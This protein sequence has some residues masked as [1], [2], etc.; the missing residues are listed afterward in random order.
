MSEQKMKQQRLMTVTMESLV[1][2][3]HFL[4]K[5][6]A[7]VDMDFIYEL[8]R[9][10]YSRRGRPSIDPVTLIKSLLIGYLYGIDSE[11]K[12]EKEIQVNIA[13]RRYIRLDLEDSVPDHSTLSQNRRRCFKGT[14]VF[15]EIFLQVVRLC[16]EAGLVKGEAIAMDSTHVRANA[17]Y[18][19]R[20]TVT[21]DTEPRE[22]LRKLEAE[23]A[24]RDTAS[25]GEKKRRGPKPKEK[26]AFHI[27]EEKKS[28]TDPDSGLLG[29]PNRPNE[30]NYL[31]HQSADVE[32]GIITDAYVTA[33]NRLDHECCV[34]RINAQKER[35]NLLLREIC[36]R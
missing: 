23:I 24:E 27:T 18:E 22:Y 30:F 36:G 25:H 28:I 8:V 20:E 31:C 16:I 2:E 12:L 29:R 13:Y 26:P 5:L 6:D 33:G 21:V 3:D 9:P 15:E 32:Y 35:L 34:E 11:R 1:P 14:T 7:A 10:L 17:N 19:K 4:R